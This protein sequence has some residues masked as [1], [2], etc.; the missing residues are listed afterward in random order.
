[1]RTVFADTNYWIALLDPR[2]GLHVEAHR[3]SKGLKDSAIATSEMVLVELLNAFS[4][5]GERSRTIAG[6]FAQAIS[7][8]P[9]VEVVPQ[10]TLHFQ[11]ALSLY[12]RRPDQRWGLTDCASMIV[13]R[14]RAID[15]VASADRHFRQAGFTTLLD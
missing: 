11:A 13:M 10:S 2:D 12:L 4:G 3:L 15:E 14:Q 9:Q 7:N 6:E 1:M 8:N 5:R